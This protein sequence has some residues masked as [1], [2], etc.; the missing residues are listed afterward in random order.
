MYYLY[1]NTSE[2]SKIIGQY[3]DKDDAIS[4]MEYLALNNMDENATGYAVRDQKF[5]TL[6]EWEV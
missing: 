1:K 2:E 6:T 5:K 3:Q 4:R